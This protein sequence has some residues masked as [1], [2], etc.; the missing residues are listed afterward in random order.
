[1]D[2]EYCIS[3]A[4][5]LGEISPLEGI[6]LNSH[7]A[8]YQAVREI[9][10]HDLPTTTPDWIANECRLALH[11][12]PERY[13]QAVSL[14]ALR[15]RDLL[16]KNMIDRLESVVQT[17]V[18]RDLGWADT[19]RSFNELLTGNRNLG[20]TLFTRESDVN[21]ELVHQLL[22]QSD[23]A[24]SAKLRL[25]QDYSE[26]KQTV[27]Q[28]TG[29]CSEDIQL[30][31][32]YLLDSAPPPSQVPVAQ[33][34]VRPAV[35]RTQR[36]LG[37][38]SVTQEMRRRAQSAI[39]KASKLFTS[40][41]KGKD[42]SMFIAGDTVTLSHPDSELKFVVR[43][44]G[45]EDWLIRR[46]VSEFTAHTP[47]ELSLLT[48]SDVYLGNLCV[49]FSES[50]VLDQLLSLSLFIEAGEEE[51]LLEKANVFG[52]SHWNDDFFAQLKLSSPALQSKWAQRKP[53]AKYATG[54][55]EL[56]VPR[57]MR[58]WQP[59]SNPTKQWIQAWLGKQV[60]EFMAMPV[61]HQ[62]ATLSWDRMDTMLRGY[63]GVAPS[64]ARCAYVDPN[65]GSVADAK[66]AID[67]STVEL[68]A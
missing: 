37:R 36:K 46:S 68:L 3:C 21:E 55:L 35:R 43:S 30:Q 7:P 42:L 29:E 44:L 13:R 14:L 4:Q 19:N 32:A 38:D 27:R 53:V 25:Q 66:R 18:S 51:A 5:E 67:L 10:D 64:P 6:V 47:F 58:L 16:V 56:P 1:M 31:L 20:P 33:S 26:F 24:L 59:F 22:N 62:L 15:S 8:V 63:L 45:S 50:P 65:A 61:P 34:P 60:S 2:T 17:H 48:K 57:S 28:L 9:V 49:Y 39:K 11:K 52:N 12:S 40:M 54:E 41:G 23:T